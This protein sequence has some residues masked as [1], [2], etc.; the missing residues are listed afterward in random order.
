[1][2]VTTNLA[3]DAA[4]FDLLYPSFGPGPTNAILLAFAV[5]VP[6]LGPNIPWEL[7]RSPGTVATAKMSF[8]STAFPG[9]TPMVT[10]YLSRSRQLPGGMTLVVQNARFAPVGD[11]T[12]VTPSILPP[13]SAGFPNTFFLDGT[14]LAD[15]TVAIQLATPTVQLAWVANGA[16]DLYD[17]QF[18]DIATHTTL[19]HVFRTTVPHV[20][21]DSADLLAGHSYVAIVTAVLGLPGVALGD[22]TTHAYPVEG[23]I[24]ASSVFTVVP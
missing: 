12:C 11:P 14:A 2:N 10:T 18:V 16:A 20:V 9:F 22:V 21:V 3:A 24:G 17:V 7:A 15:D 5:G 13:H 1:M 8:N 4:R 23:G 19:P 6:A